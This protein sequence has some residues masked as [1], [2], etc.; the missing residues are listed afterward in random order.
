MLKRELAANYANTEHELEE[1]S[2]DL[3]LP[4]GHTGTAH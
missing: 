3:P 2:G 1:G 4:L